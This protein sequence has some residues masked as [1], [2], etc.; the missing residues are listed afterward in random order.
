[1][2]LMQS[3]VFIYRLAVAV[4]AMATMHCALTAAVGALRMAAAIPLGRRGP[5]SQLSR[6]SSAAVP[7]SSSSSS[8]SSPLLATA[9]A[10]ATERVRSPPLPTSLLPGPT[11]VTLRSLD[12]PRREVL[13]RSRSR[14][15]PELDTLLGGFAE[16]RLASLT[17]AQVAMFAELL[18]RENAELLRWLSGQALVP[19]E[20]LESNAVLRMLL[21]HVHGAHPSLAAWDVVAPL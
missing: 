7:S 14:K 21:R 18:N 19:Q 6:C 17:D 5:S 12:G 20:V 10:T 3:R 16:R 1:M 4:A 13:W 9:M 8:S 11:I 2:L 15:W